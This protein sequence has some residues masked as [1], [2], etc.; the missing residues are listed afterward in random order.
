ME[1]KKP[2][3]SDNILL[4]LA[5]N[6]GL[7]SNTGSK[8]GRKKARKASTHPADQARKAQERRCEK[9]DKKRRRIAAKS[10]RINRR[11]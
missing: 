5:L 6:G 1:E 9:K 3:V 4:A 10:R 11:G 8:P 2:T 7:F